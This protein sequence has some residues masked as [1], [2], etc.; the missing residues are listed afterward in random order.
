[1]IKLSMMALKNFI[2]TNKS[3]GKLARACKLDYSQWTQN[4]NAGRASK[5]EYNQQELRYSFKVA[6]KTNKDLNNNQNQPNK[7]LWVR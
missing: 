3:K 1:M 6:V 4:K 2:I 7:M 5:S